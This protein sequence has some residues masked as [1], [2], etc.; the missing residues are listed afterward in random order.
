MIINADY[1]LAY[2]GYEMLIE[3][4]I[5]VAEQVVILFLLIAVGLTMAKVK[6]VDD[7]G[8]RQMTQLLLMIVTPCVIIDSFQMDFSVDLLTGLVISVIS[9]VVSHFVGILLGRFLFK[10]HPDSDRKIMRYSIIFSNCGFMCIPLLYAVLGPIGVFYGSAYIAVFNIV[11]WTYGIILMTGDRQDINLRRAL[12]N[13]GTIGMALGLL[14]FL[15]GIT[16]P[17]VPATVV[18]SL[19][20]LNTPIAMIIIGAQMAKTSLLE[21][22]KNKIN[23]QVAFWRLLVVPLI[24][25]TLLVFLPIDRQLLIACIIPASAPTAAATALFATIYRQNVLLATHTITLTTI[26]SIITMPLLI[27]AADTVRY[28]M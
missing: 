20:A 2:G 26:L 12:I 8:I 1:K 9:A 22:W 4:A 10:K 15:A 13:P 16:L 3:S 11:Q 19:A 21:I 14:F 23:Y 24:M 18:S 5:V 7:N 28:F 27:L 17:K 6:W 25:M